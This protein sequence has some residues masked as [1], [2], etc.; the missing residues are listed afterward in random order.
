MASFLGEYPVSMDA[1]GRIKLPAALKRQLD[2]ASGGR[3]VINRGFEKCLVLYPFNE[4]EKI[5][6]RLST[7]NLFEKKNRQFVR[8][9]QRGATELIL[10]ATDRLNIPNHLSKYA[11]IS[12]DLMLSARN[13]VIEVWNPK[14]YDELLSMDS[15]AFAKLAEEVMGDKDNPNEQ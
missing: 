1:K 5:N 3:F 9:F 6:A 12:K 8:Y 15:D 11:D 4:W 10:D 13:N 7:L 14:V 2:P